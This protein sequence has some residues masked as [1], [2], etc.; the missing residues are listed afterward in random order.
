MLS[1]VLMA[2]APK[3]NV[4]GRHTKMQEGSTMHTSKEKLNTPF[5]HEDIVYN[6][7]ISH[8]LSVNVDDNQCI[9]H[10][11]ISAADD[12]SLRIFCGPQAAN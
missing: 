5:S 4:R 10:L 1:N 7:H 6:A 9:Q 12:I 3:D 11:R 8:Q 2:H